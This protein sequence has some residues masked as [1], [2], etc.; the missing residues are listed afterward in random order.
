MF[1]FLGMSS[2]PIPLGR[3][4]S[5]LQSSLPTQTNAAL[6]I[7]IKDLYQHFIPLFQ[8]VGDLPD[9]VF[10]DLGDMNQS[11]RPWV[12]LH[13]GA[14]PEDSLHLSCVK[15]P[16]LY[17]LREALDHIDG[18]FNGLVVWGSQLHDPR[19][20]HIHFYTRLIDNAPD[21]LSSRADHV[22]DLLLFN[23]ERDDP[24]GMPGKI[25]AGFWNGLSHFAQNMELPFT[26]LMEDLF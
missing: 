15:S 1:R 3:G 21:I 19:I 13:N 10:C 18:F 26:G 24:R 25:F 12:E 14:K 11:I 22:A 7:D 4:L 5:L 6:R 2:L 17:F 9:T 16:Y 23:R 20:L 8:D